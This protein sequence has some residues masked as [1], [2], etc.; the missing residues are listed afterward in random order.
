MGAIDFG[1]IVPKPK[2]ILQS[3]RLGF[4][5]HVGYVNVLWV[6]IY[7]ITTQRTVTQRVVDAGWLAGT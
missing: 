6:G 4:W 7:G 1:Q 2:D 5:W 3:N